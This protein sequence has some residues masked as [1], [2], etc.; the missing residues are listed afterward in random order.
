MERGNHPPLAN[1]GS[2]TNTTTGLPVT[3]NGSGSSDPDGDALAFLWRFLSVPPPSTVTDALLANGDTAAPRF[4][5]DVD[6]P[7]VLAIEA[8]D[9]A[10]SAVDTVIVA[11]RAANVPPN[12]NAGP[13][14]SAVAGQSV[15]LDGRGSTDPDNGPAPPGFRW[16]FAALPPGSLLSDIDIA[17]ANTALAS[18]TPDFAGDYRISL[19]VDDG[20]DTGRDEV[21]ISAALPNVAPNADAGADR[22]VQLGGD[23]TLDG[24]ASN[25]PDAGPTPLSFQ[26]TFVSVAPG[27]GL[28]DTD[29]SGA[30]TVAPSFTPD[31]AGFYVLRLDVS[32][33]DLTDTDQV[34]VKANVAPTAVDDPRTLVE[35][36][37]LN[38]PAP[39]VLGNDTDGNNDVL[40]AV[41]DSGPTN[42]TL[43]LNAD[44]SFSYTPDT[45][46]EGPD[47]FT[48]HANDGSADSSPA[49]VTIT[50]THANEAPVVT[51][52][53]TLNFSEDD[54]AAVIDGTVTVNDVDSVNLTDATVQITGNYQNGADV[55]SFATIG[56]ISSSFDVPSG[57]LTLSGTDTL[58]NYQ[59]ALQNVMYLNNSN[60]PITAART[61]TWIGSDGTDASLPVTSTITVAATNDGP[62]IAAGGTLAY[63]EGGP[64][65][66]IDLLLTV[67][68]PDSLNLTGATIQITANY[69][70]GADVLSFAN[71]PPIS[72][73]FDVPSGTLTLSG[74]DT[75][76]NY[77]TALRT[78]RYQNTSGGPSPAPRTVSWNATDGITPSNT[79][80]STI[81]LSVINDPPQ[82]SGGPFLIA[83][84]SANGSPVGTVA[85]NDPDAGQT[86]TFTITGGNTGDAFTIDP[87]TGAI[88]VND[89]AAL[90]FETAPSFSLTVEVTDS[91]TPPL[92]G[93]TTVT[94]NL[95]DAN[96]PPV[97]TPA[98]F[99]PAEN[100]ANGTVVG[101]VTAT[102]L[103]VPAQTL[104]FAITG[105][106]TGGAFAINAST[107]QLT[108][109]STAALDFETT[110]SFS[111]TVQATDNGVLPLSGTATVTVNLTDVNEAPV[112]TG[113]PFSIAENSPNTTSV[114]SVAAGDPDAGQTH[115]FA[116]T[117][118]N[119]GGTFAINTM[120]GAIT[121]AS[122]SALDFETT[123][124][125][126]LTVEVTDNGTPALNGS[127]SVVINL[128]NVNE[129]PVP[130]GG[131]FS[132]PENSANGTPVGT[133]A[134]NDP[135]AGQTHT[136]TI[137]A[138][139]TGGAFAI[140]NSGQI[141]VAAVAAVNFELNPVFTLTVQA[142]DNGSPV[143]SGT[144]PVTVNLLNVNEAPVAQDKTY[145][146]QA[147]MQVGIAAGA[148]L[149]N[150][151]T[152]EDAGTVLTLNTV[153]ATTPAGGTIAFTPATGE[154]T[155]DPPPGVTTIAPAGVTFTYQICDNGLPA[156]CDTATVTVP[157]SG[158]VIWFV[159][160]GASGTNDG[161]L[162]NPFT[163][164]GSVPAVDNA[165]DRVFVF[166]GTYTNGLALLSGEQLIGQGVTGT[167]FDNFFS[168]TPPPG[169]IA[170][171]A[172]NGTRPT[173]QNTVTLNT[174]GIVRGLN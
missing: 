132:L 39:G 120:T 17:G 56:P 19:D 166:T 128:T 52:G 5:P 131:P 114:G 60:N 28:S 1:A 108:V 51:A 172:I 161:R 111:L 85:A 115:T 29:L 95:S 116:I 99:S 67:T 148:G 140:D 86:H 9:G 30:T 73:S 160:Q 136:F 133:V 49:T 141:T 123:P 35:N 150:G 78:V 8:S 113:G 170:R 72:G 18:F 55:L 34:L 167:G 64:A 107:G 137:T 38:E 96:D 156:L 15:N 13:D 102:D 124:S 6:G 12:A 157:V 118:G 105:G 24:A 21:L 153:S 152:D 70:N 82:P 163:S 165:N 91:D 40:T 164:L 92:S 20:A 50:V 25:D 26:W 65:T 146:A 62:V 59:L 81:T 88:T 93:N 97:V 129:A 90:D 106:N 155:F 37:S 122:S 58:A 119:T 110:P 154:F 83:E 143:L 66:A 22:V 145:A 127:A 53:A 139:N 45:D 168:I 125:F 44:G 171:P 11:A 100:S 126:S 68:D 10:M 36:T 7:Y 89:S 75:V 174:N 98:T 158:P 169:T 84:N 71:S 61:V 117:G 32:D 142:T 79:A 63:T 135:D 23:A 41:L 74:A 47:G 14:A 31:L 43:I 134:A 27:S 69:Q 112:P 54:S 2:D 46:F 104:S 3:L 159:Q 130:S 76:A 149:L 162:S 80:T 48:Y 16:S 147:N 33:G 4:T 151:A 57:T 121:V 101:T 77:E 109:A 173:L 87:G 94:I 138:G 144:A 103:D 42:G